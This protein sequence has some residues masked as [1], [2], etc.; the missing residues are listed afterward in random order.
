MPHNLWCL[1]RW[2]RRS[3]GK[4][5]TVWC[6]VIGMGVRSSAGLWGEV[7][8]LVQGG[9]CMGVRV[10]G[11]GLR[12]GVESMAHGCTVWCLEYGAG[13]YGLV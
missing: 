3:Y 5:C 1:R 4:G 7:Y 6:K 13:V 9:W 2:R 10:M 12:S 8:L 11:R